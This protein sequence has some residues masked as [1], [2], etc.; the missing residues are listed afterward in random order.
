MA[1]SGYLTSKG[2]TTV[3]KAIRDTL[4]I[5]VGARLNW[6][7]EGDR[8]IVTIGKRSVAELAGILGNPL[9]CPVSIEEMREC[10]AEAASDRFGR[11]LDRR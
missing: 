8:M 4:G 3:P 5:D 1:S 7:V 11:S 6:S 2:Q 9:G 10:V